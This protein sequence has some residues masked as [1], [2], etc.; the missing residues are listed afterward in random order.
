MN[1][2]YLK[3]KLKGFFGLRKV[4]YKNEPYAYIVAKFYSGG[5]FFLEGFGSE[6]DFDIARKNAWEY[7]SKNLY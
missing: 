2:I 4:V 7:V 5:T 1:W 6:E 3:L